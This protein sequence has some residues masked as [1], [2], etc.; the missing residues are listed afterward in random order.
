MHLGSFQMVWRLTEEMFE[1]QGEPQQLKG[2]IGHLF[3]VDRG[4]KAT[5]GYV[6]GSGFCFNA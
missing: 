3:I 2:E 6:S 4:E 5:N 1:Y